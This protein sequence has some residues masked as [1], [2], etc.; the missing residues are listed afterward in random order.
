MTNE[1]IKFPKDFVW[2]TAT[3]SHQIE[4]AV[5]EDGRTP[6]IW[7]TFSHTP[8]KIHDATNAD[9]ACDHYHRV[10]ED[11]DIISNLVPNYRFST[12]WTRILPDGTGKV[13][14]KGVDFYNRL[15]D[16]L[17]EKGV[18]PWLTMYHW[19]LPQSL[20]DKGGWTSRDIIKWFEEYASVLVDNFSDRVKNW[21]IINE[22]SVISVKGYGWGAHAPGL[23]GEDNILSSTH[24][25]NMTIGNTYNLVK[26]INDKLNVGST[27]NLMPIKPE[28]SDTPQEAFEHID[29]FWNRNFFDPLIL[30][31][32]PRVIREAI[33]KYVKDGDMDVTKTDLDFVGVQHY[34]PDLAAH[35]PEYPFNA[36]FG[37]PGDVP[38][39]DIGWVIDPQA[40]H[41]VLVDFK[42]RY[43][44][45][46]LYVTENGCAFSDPVVDGE[47]K[48]DRRV[49]FLN[50][51]IRAMHK[52]ITE[53]NV[54]LKGYFLWSLMDNYEW[55]FGYEQRF[56]IVHVDYE[57]LKRTPKSSYYWYQKLV[58]ENG[59]LKE[60]DVAA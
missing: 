19:D 11:T 6:S 25:I 18:D 40:F 26:S 28:N 30:G 8:G 1:T 53:G 24:H 41:D 57:T 32:Y 4:G 14:P 22:P 5:N 33:S 15:I 52:A 7:D 38:K 48:D 42:N 55:E 39:T 31:E 51:Y 45:V 50:G 56:G 46:P 2:G 49:A 23:T 17:L 44:D 58:K 60:K 59:L 36:F 3:S 35:N 29:G 21:A 43:G 27:Y 37:D 16:T 20:E 12:S 9:V 13:N 47:C 34:N 54:N 10:E